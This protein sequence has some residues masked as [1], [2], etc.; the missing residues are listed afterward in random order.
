MRVKLDLKE[1]ERKA[2]YAAFQDGLM[3]I[4]MGLFLV[5]FGVAL[6]TNVVVTV[7][8]VLVTVFFAN[9]AIERLKRRCIY[10]CGLCQ[11]ARRPTNHRQRHRYR[12]GNHGGGAAGCDGRL[13]GGP[14]TGNRGRLLPDLHIA[15]RNWIYAG[16]R[17]LLVGAGLWPYARLCVGS[18][19]RPGRPSH[20]RV[21]DRLRV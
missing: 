20:A 6:V 11:A 8:L 10:P 19:L 18:A 7:V 9:P 1:I 5:F 14:G 17:P 3:E 12:S 15:A 16:D 4:F 21:W 2:N 13:D